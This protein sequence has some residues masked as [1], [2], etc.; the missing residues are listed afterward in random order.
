VPRVP[1]V[2][3]HLKKGQQEMGEQIFN[4]FMRIP[5]AGETMPVDEGRMGTSPHGGRAKKRT[6]GLC[7]WGSSTHRVKRNLR[8]GQQALEYAVLIAAISMALT[9]MYVYGKRG[10]QAVIKDSAD[11]IGSQANSQPA[12]GSII[13][14]GTSTLT[15]VTN[16]ITG[17][18]QIGGEK[19]YNSQSVSTTQGVSQ[20]HTESY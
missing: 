19:N 17:V 20:T 14:S 16:D 3:L 12:A 2:G 4:P 8:Q 5:K 18:N 11:Q 6:H 7:P 15:T 13:T 1:P 10:I 9:V